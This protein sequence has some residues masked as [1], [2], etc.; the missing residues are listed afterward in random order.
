MPELGFPELVPRW[1]A[2]HYVAAGI[3]L[4]NVHELRQALIAAG[5]TDHAT[6]VLDM[7]QTAFCDSNALN[8]LIRARKRA[9]A[10]GG[11][12]RLVIRAAS[13]LRVFAVTG[14]DWMFPIFASLPE[15]LAPGPHGALAPLPAPAG[16]RGRA[17]LRATRHTRP[18]RSAKA[19]GPARSRHHRMTRPVTG[20]RGLRP[21]GNHPR[22][23]DLARYG[24]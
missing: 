17:R 1:V 4:A 13:L 18:S 5:D 16:Q 15:A 10:G 8:V 6:V 12:V 21:L 14:T 24:N 2:D 11:E 19:P 9:A 3:D 20:V 22:P 23:G 7:T